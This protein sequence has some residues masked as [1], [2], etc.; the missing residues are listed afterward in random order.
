MASPREVSH[1][2]K[3]CGGPEIVEAATDSLCAVFAMLSIQQATVVA[4]VFESLGS[5]GDIQAPGPD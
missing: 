3:G 5:E 4:F 1:V 2:L